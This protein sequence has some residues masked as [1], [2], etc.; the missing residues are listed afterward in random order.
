MNTITIDRDNAADLLIQAVERRGYDHT[1]APSGDSSGCTYIANVHPLGFLVAVCLIGEVFAGLGVLRALT[2]DGGR[3]QFGA[4]DPYDAEFWNNAEDYG[5]YV[6]QDARDLFY[7]AQ[8]KQDS[9][10][11]WGVAVTRSIEEIQVDD[12]AKLDA[13]HREEQD[14]LSRGTMYSAT[15]R[16]DGLRPPVYN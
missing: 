13:K 1:P 6:E 4:C 9:G 5:I 8:R 12:K 3:T 16:L 7:S 14:A 2:R 11:S 15:A 10:K